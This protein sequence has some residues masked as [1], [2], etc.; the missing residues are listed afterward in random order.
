MSIRY[1]SW[2]WGQEVGSATT[3]IVLLKLADNSNDEGLSWPSQS[4]LAKHTELTRETINRHIKK[5]AD[6]GILEV[7]HRSQDGVSLPN[8]Y[9]FPKIDGARGV[10]TEDHRGCDGESQGGVTENHT[11]PSFEP[12]LNLKNGHSASP[13]DRF[14]DFWKAYPVKKKKKGAR[15]AWKRKKLDTK[16]DEL[17]AD[18]EARGKKDGQWLKGFIP[19]ATSYI[20]GELWEDEIEPPRGKDGQPEIRPPHLRELN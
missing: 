3:K 5:L 11:E 19:H 15:E 1:L 14:E 10:V 16:A 8:H 13:P 18:V 6:A 17:I 4:Y 7:I 2:A 12:S 20:N 9:Q